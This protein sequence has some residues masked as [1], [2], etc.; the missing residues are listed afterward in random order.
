LWSG[1]EYLGV[2]V[3]VAHWCRLG[4][5]RAINRRYISD[6]V[7]IKQLTSASA[8]FVSASALG[9]AVGPAIASLLSSVDFKVFQ[10]HL[11]LAGFY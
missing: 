10:P 6:H 3:C 4:G 2:K 7:P 1:E 8:A 11:H 9:M 5:A